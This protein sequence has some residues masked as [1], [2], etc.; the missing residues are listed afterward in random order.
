VVDTLVD[1]W[2]LDENWDGESLDDEKDRSLGDESL[3]DEKDGESLDNVSL[4]ENLD[5]DNATKDGRSVVV[6][7]E[8]AEEDSADWDASL[9]RRDVVASSLTD[10]SYG[11]DWYFHQLLEEAIH[12]YYPCQPHHPVDY[13]QDCL[14]ASPNQCTETVTILHCHYSNTV[15]GPCDTIHPIMAR[16]QTNIAA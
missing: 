5:E 16:H 6:V 9:A 8:V 10:D 14:E 2:S 1:I 11:H 15:L 3:D 7:V 13:H 12:R 4:D